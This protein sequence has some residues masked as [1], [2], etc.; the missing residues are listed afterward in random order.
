MYIASPLW[1]DP[2][3]TIPGVDIIGV[4]PL[5]PLSFLHRLLH[6]PNLVVIALSVGHEPSQQIN[7]I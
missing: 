6:S 7:K 1:R 2:R 4:G 3:D 5:P